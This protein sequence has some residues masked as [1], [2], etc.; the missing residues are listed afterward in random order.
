MDAAAASAT[1]VGP[2]AEEAVVARGAVRRMYADTSGVALV[3]GADVAVAWTRAAG[4]LEV[5]RGRAAVPVQRVAIVA[6]LAEIDGPVA[7]DRLRNEDVGEAVG[8]VGDQV[9][10]GAPE[11]D[12][13]TIG[14]CHG[15]KAH[16]VS[17]VAI[18]IQADLVGRARL[19]VVDE[20]VLWRK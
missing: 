18:G 16:E 3:V 8:V 4:G 6:V 17:P 12:Q 15:R 13:V 10:G 19:P 7:T 20:D 1:G 2:V 11:R 9:G 14:R 5:T